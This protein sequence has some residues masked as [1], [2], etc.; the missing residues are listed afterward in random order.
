LENL[1]LLSTTHECV[2]E[3]DEKTGDLRYQGPSPD[4]IALVDAARRMGF[5]F[6]GTSMNNLILEI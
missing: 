3:T 1:F 4:E 5:K 2:L 6:K